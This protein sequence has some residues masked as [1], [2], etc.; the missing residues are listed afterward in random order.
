MNWP[1]V[2]ATRY[3]T[4]GIAA[5]DGVLVTS[6]VVNGKGAFATIGT[7]AFRYSGFFLTFICNSTARGTIDVAVNNGGSDQ[8]IV[9]DFYMPRFPTVG[10][11]AQYKIWFPVAI[12]AGAAVKVRFRSTSAAQTANAG[13]LGYA[14]DLKGNVGFRGCFSLTDFGATDPTNSVTQTGTAFTA[15]TTICASSQ[16]RAAGIYAVMSGQGDTTRTASHMQVD[17]GIGAAGS[18]TTLFSILTQ[19]TTTDPNSD[20]HFVPCDI[21]AGKRLAFRCKCALAAADS[22]GVSVNGLAA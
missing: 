13:V 11:L 8:L 15:W 17:I 4:L 16:V 21:P 20:I 14:Q 1:L 19:Q 18:E 6:G 12:P 22:L 9:Q 2:A 10:T 3:D 5:G 7:A